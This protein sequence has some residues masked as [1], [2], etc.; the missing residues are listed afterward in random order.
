MTADNKKTDDFSGV[1]IEIN[2]FN[3]ANKGICIVIERLFPVEF[4]T[5]LARTATPQDMK[6]FYEAVEK[7][8]A[9]ICQNFQESQ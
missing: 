2:C 7:M 5:L 6:K 9:R 3:C 8:L 4:K 1:M